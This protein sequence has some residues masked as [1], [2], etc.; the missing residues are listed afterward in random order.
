MA[1]AQEPQVHDKR[2]GTSTFDHAGEGMPAFVPAPAR[3]DASFGTF[4]FAGRV[5]Q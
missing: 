4:A 1:T 5:S 3:I 2:P